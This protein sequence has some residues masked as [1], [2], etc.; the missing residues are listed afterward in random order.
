V[1][2]E[3]ATGMFVM[4]H[5]NTSLVS[6]IPVGSFRDFILFPLPSSDTEYREYMQRVC[7]RFPPGTLRVIALNGHEFLT[8]PISALRVL[9]PN[10]IALEARSQIR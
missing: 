5:R 1:P 8:G 2:L 10:T 4:R 9:F 3:S 7:A 6:R